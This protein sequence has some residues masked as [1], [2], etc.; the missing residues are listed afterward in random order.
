[1]CLVQPSYEFFDHTADMGVRVFAPTLPGLIAPAGDGLYAVIGRLVGQ[2]DARPITFELTGDRPAELLRD[3]LGE[4][5]ILFERDARVVTAV[6]VSTF[7]DDRL[8]AIVSARSVD[9][10]RS[11]FHREVK[12]VTYHELNIAAIPGGYEATFIVDI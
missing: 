10:Q 4:L 1:M 6:D 5:L 9:A 12:A 7:N 3:Y 11:V 8:A 2:G